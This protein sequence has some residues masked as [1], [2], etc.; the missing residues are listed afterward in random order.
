MCV[1]KM[2][3]P[4]PP[5]NG[6]GSWLHFCL[7]GPK[8]NATRSALLPH[9]TSGPTHQPLFASMI[10]VIRFSF[11]NFKTQSLFGRTSSG[12]GSNICAILIGRSYKKHGYWTHARCYDLSACACKSVL[13]GRCPQDDDVACRRGTCCW[14]WT[15]KCTASRSRRRVC[16]IQQD[17]SPSNPPQVF[18][19]PNQP[20]G[21]QRSICRCCR[22]PSTKSRLSTGFSNNKEKTQSPMSLQ[23]GYLSISHPFQLYPSFSSSQTLR[24]SLDIGIVKTKEHKKRR[25]RV[26][27]KLQSYRN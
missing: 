3:P 11:S 10:V 5:L 18:W 20:E 26:C 15:A 23:A 19:L 25:I 17:S 7:N 6:P 27:Y 22:T 9:Q 4:P 2:Q 21:I 8:E 14:R 24:Y 13:L 1:H 16:P 12:L